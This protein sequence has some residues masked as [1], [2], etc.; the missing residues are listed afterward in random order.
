M[1]ATLCI[2]LALGI[3]ATVTP[4][5][6]VDE[7]HDTTRQCSEIYAPGR[8]IPLPPMEAHYLS[9]KSMVEPSYYPAGYVVSYILSLEKE[10]DSNARGE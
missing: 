5:E 4:G 3:A 9:G 7:P 8:N 2:L 10:R 1:H 6:I